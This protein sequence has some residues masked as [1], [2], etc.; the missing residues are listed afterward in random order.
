MYSMA[1]NYSCTDLKGDVVLVT[2]DE[3]LRQIRLLR[4]NTSILF[5]NIQSEYDGRMA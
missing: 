3:R 2:F 4:K 1:T 5:L